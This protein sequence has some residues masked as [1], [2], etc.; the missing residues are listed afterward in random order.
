MIIDHIGIVTKSIED[1]IILWEKSFGY[2]Q[3]TEIITN[4]RQKVKVV[5]L[6]KEKSITV[7]LVEPIENNTTIKKFAFNGGGLHHICFKTSDMNTEIATLVKNRFRVITE[8]QPGE[9]FDNEKISFL[10]GNGI[11]IE[12]IDT[13]KKAKSLK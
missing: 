12:L 13:D 5:F 11:N 9:A 8:P 1:G 2:K 3:Q 10:Y 7:K 4:T 6:C